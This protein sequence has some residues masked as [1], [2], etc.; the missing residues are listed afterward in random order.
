M[1]TI[2][3]WYLEIIAKSDIRQ[4]YS[5]ECLRF[6]LKINIWINAIITGHLKDEAKARLL[7][8]HN[9]SHRPSSVINVSFFNLK[10]NQMLLF[11][12]YFW[13]TIWLSA[14]A[15]DSIRYFFRK[16]CRCVAYII[17][18]IIIATLPN[19]ATSLC[20]RVYWV[21]MVRYIE[22]IDV[23]FSISIYR[24]ISYSQ[25]YRLFRYIAI[26]FIYHDIF[27]TYREILRQKFIFLLLH[28]TNNENKRRKRRT[29][30][31]KRT[32]VS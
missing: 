21:V 23:S 26:S 16:R 11:S 13:R 2:F 19:E 18:V 3:G 1:Q 4:L 5:A 12:A 24:I 8:V 17:I 30:R 28:Y 9:H 10:K 29:N 32:I 31:S 22:N 15:L 27:E 7:A 14:A 25:K 6:R 20:S